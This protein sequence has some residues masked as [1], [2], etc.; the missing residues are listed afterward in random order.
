VNA[1]ELLAFA[2]GWQAAA[3]AAYELGRRDAIASF[4]RKLEES[5][6]A[7]GNMAAMAAIADDAAAR[8]QARLDRR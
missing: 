8:A 1:T 5:A 7:T 6:V 4:V 3:E 2:I